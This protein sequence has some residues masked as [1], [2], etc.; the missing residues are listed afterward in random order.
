[1]LTSRVGVAKR[2]SY[3]GVPRQRLGSTP[4]ALVNVIGSLSE[5]HAKFGPDILGHLI[6]GEGSN[7]YALDGIIAT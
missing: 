3:C 5:G 1:V 6:N 4:T 2:R 7:E